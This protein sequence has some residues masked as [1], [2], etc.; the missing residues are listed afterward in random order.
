MNADYRPLGLES[1]DVDF[2][3]HV[4]IEAGINVLPILVLYAT[5][6]VDHLVRFCFCIKDA[7]LQRAVDRLRAFFRP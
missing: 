3:R 2:C 5:P 6:G 4:T 1:T 7:V